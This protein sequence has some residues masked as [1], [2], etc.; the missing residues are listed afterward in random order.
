MREWLEDFRWGM[1][2]IHWNGLVGGRFGGENRWGRLLGADRIAMKVMPR[3]EA[4]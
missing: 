2:A 3:N 1:D 4:R